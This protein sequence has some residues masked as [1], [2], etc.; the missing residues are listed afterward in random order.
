LLKSDLWC[1]AKL[2]PDF[3]RVKQVATVVPWTI[4]YIGFAAFIQAEDLL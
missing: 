1:P 3:G 4:F 2:A